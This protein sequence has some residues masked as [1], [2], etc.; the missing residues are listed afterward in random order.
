MKTRTYPYKAWTLKP[1]F[2]PVEVELVAQS[3]PG[4]LAHDKWDATEKRKHYATDDLF[5]TKADAITEGWARIEKQAANLAKS[6]ETL[7]KKREA[8]RKA[9]A[10]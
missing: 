3:W 2:A 7:E 5:P 6:L 1:S 8:L 9:G 4:L 10:A